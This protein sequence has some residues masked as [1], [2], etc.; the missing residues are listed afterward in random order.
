[1]SPEWVA[2]LI[3]AAALILQAISTFPL[4]DKKRKDKG[5]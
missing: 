4:K 5:E 1:M 2:V 3:A